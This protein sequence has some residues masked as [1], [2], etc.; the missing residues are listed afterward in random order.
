MARWGKLKKILLL[1]LVAVLPTVSSPARTVPDPTDAVGFFTTVAD[2]LLRSTFS[3]GI[4]NIPIAL[5]EFNP[6]DHTTNV[7]DCGG[8]RRAT[9]LSPATKMYSNPVRQ[10][11]SKRNRPA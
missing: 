5:K 4:T 2:K 3:F 9:P 1:G 7:M 11:G 6:T 10:T 8:K